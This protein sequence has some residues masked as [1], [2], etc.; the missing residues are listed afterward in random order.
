ML[1]A[2]DP[3]VV[4]QT[5]SC[6]RYVYCTIRVVHSRDFSMYNLRILCSHKIGGLYEQL[7]RAVFGNSGRCKARGYRRHTRKHG[8]LRCAVIRRKAG[9][10]GCRRRRG[11]SHR[12]TTHQTRT[13]FRQ[14]VCRLVRRPDDAGR[15]ISDR[16]RSRARLQCALQD[17]S[18]MAARR[19]RSRLHPTGSCD[20]YERAHSDHGVSTR[21]P[22]RCQMGCRH[23]GNFAD[24]RCSAARP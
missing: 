3:P 6:A 17:R 2:T 24:H 20:G 16:P 18:G 15:R 8:G 14:S 9:R 10:T 21:H 11:S 13:T 7:V 1:I 12:R 5:P 22:G 23:L 19:N 4:G